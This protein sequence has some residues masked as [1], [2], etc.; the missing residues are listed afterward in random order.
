MPFEYARTA[1]RGDRYKF[2]AVLHSVG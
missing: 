2:N 1:Y